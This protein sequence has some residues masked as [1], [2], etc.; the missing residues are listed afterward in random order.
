MAYSC[1]DVSDLNQTTIEDWRAAGI[2]Y[3][4]GSYVS[5]F[6][7][8]NL[9][10]GWQISQALWQKILRKSDS[11]FL[12][13]D[14]DDIPFEAITQCYP[15]R[16]TIRS[17]I[18]KMFCEE[19]PNNIHRC[20]F[21]S[22]KTGMASS[23]ITTNYDLAFDSLAE[24]D[25]ECATIFDQ[26]TFDRYCQARSPA[27]ASSYVYFK[28]HGT[29]APGAEQT[30]VC[31]LEAEGWP[32]QWKRDLL[33][34]ITKDRSLIVLGYS[35]RDFDICPEL[36]NYTQQ[37]RTIWLHS[38]HGALQA[39][40]RRVLTRKGGIVVVGD[41][42]DFLRRLVDPYLVVPTPAPKAV[43]L[44]GFD[45]AC[46]NDWRLNLLNWIA[47]SK[48]LFESFPDL[49][50]KPELRRALYGHC[51]RYRDAIDELAAE[52]NAKTFSATEKL[53]R[54]I[55]LASARFIYG[56]H[57]RAW[58][59]LNR[60]DKGFLSQPSSSD[61]LRSLV[62]ETRMVMYMRAAQVARI[63]R[64]MPVLRHIHRRAQPL[65]VQARRILQN[66][67]SWGRLEALQQNAE[68][69]GIATPDGLPMPARRGYRSL[70]LLSM[71]VIMKRDWIRS[72][73]WHLNPDKQ[74]EA[75]EYIA[76]AEQDGWH[77]EAWKLN[78]IMLW[79][80]TGD[81]ATYFRE[82][83][84]HFRATQYPLFAKLLQLFLNLF[85]TGPEH[86]FDEEDYWS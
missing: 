43:R 8:T 70:G 49:A 65:Y 33:F 36:A 59:A 30:I 14:L 37:A 17:I 6:P 2:V 63:F 77:H 32:A 11:T 28:I 66:L 25:P 31:D 26:I 35:G 51:G 67:G 61:D 1:I 50:D 5:I 54:T 22:L 13:R 68:R 79:R 29:A 85:P 34:E 80:G 72:G 84:K 20:L 86:T 75:K 24:R 41:L 45:L 7:P 52:L 18:H 71:D 82:W 21:S 78:W 23:L 3:L 42:I 27:G 48:L 4:V 19:Q 38:P 40:A 62:M 60:V 15:Q 81:K 9:P 46:M 16:N 74:R 57:L 76:K 69:I 10:P 64:L 73:N 58:A 53:E 55:Q 12:G 44:D 47:C 39:N 56:Q 83:R